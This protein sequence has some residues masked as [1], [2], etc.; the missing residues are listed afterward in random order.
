MQK[1]K[2]ILLIGKKNKSLKAHKRISIGLFDQEKL[3]GF[4]RYVY[5][6]LVMSTRSQQ[7]TLYSRTGVFD[8]HLYTNLGLCTL[9]GR[10]Q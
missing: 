6:I 10:F 4:D 5:V 9:F 3:T 1:L 8:L 2:I 7:V